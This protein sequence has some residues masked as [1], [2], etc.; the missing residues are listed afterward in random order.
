MGD[1]TRL[2]A[3]LLPFLLAGC[4]AR[5]PLGSGTVVDLTHA[6]DEKAIYWPTE[7][8]FQHALYTEGMSEVG[9]WY[10]SGRLAA[11]EHGGTHID[12]PFHFWRTGSKVDAIPVERLIGP[13]V[14]VDV[15]EACSRDRDYLVTVSDLEEWEARHGRIPEGAIVLLRTG[16]GAFYPDRA[17]YMGTAELGAEA[18]PKLHFPGLH[19]EAARWI[20]AG[21][22][23]G[24]VGL[25]TPSIDHGPSTQFASHVA[26]FEQGIPALE[27]VA[28]LDRLPER[29]FTVI[30]LPMKIGGGTGG[31]LRIVAVLPD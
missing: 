17:R 11:A 31:P 3:V 22:A 24:A 2:C 30:A 21:R 29:G 12:A 14:V 4:A 8:L 5:Q 16:F 6:F 27:N 15:S 25:D 20:A 10:A 28:N 18:V 13:G 7:P 23:I 19:P 26:L 9:H 1:R